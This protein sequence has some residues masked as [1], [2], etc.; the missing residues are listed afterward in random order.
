MSKS[1]VTWLLTV[2]L[3]VY[4]SYTLWLATAIGNYWFLLWTAGCFIAGVGLVLSRKWAQYFVYIVAFFTAGGLIYVMIMIAVN[5]WPY[6]LRNT[7]LVLAR[8]FLI[9]ALCVLS[10]VFV[11]KHFKRDGA[12][13]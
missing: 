3:L 8:S 12:Q 6:G 4:G 1:V 11:Y 9:V 2:L 7:I 13:T 10:S 5:G